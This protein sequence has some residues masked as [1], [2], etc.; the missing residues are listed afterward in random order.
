[1]RNVSGTILEVFRAVDRKRLQQLSRVPHIVIV[2]TS[3]WGGEHLL[4]E[5]GVGS[6]N[7]PA[8]TNIINDLENLKS[9]DAPDIAPET[10]LSSE[11]LPWPQACARAPG[12]VCRQTRP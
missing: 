10:K 8:P 7:L 2:A 11:G 5:Q 4:R 9:A 3:D 6:S 1:V 12:A